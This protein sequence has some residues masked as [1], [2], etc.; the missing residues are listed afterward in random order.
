MKERLK[1]LSL[2]FLLLILA[3]PAIQ[4]F[5]ADKPAG[6]PAGHKEDV[7]NS[8]QY[9]ALFSASAFFNAPAVVTPEIATPVELSSSDINRLV[10]PEDIK[11]VIYS[12]EKGVTVKIEGRNA[13][14][15]FLVMKDGEKDIYSATPTELYVVCGQKTFNLIALPKRVPSR[16]VI[17]SGVDGKAKKNASLFEGMPFEK[18][19]LSIVKSVYTEDIPDSFTVREENRSFDLFKRDGLDLTL[20]RS[21]RIDG[22]GLRVKE[23]NVKAREDLEL[24]EKDFLKRELTSNPV[25]IAIDKLKLAPGETAR[26]IIVERV[27]DEGGN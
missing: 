6:Q 27:T 10:C 16:T 8:G 18:K 11:D 23:F 12:K 24:S 17:L 13:F 20:V 25:A 9:D 3:L 19:I 7:R 26:V 14:V 22:Q 15:K 5:A 1:V 4:V 2:L 21:V